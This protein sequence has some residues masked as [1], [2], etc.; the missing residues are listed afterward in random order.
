MANMTFKTNLLPNSTTF[1][2]SLGS[3]TDNK[4]WKIEGAQVTADLTLYT[5]SGDSP[6][7]IFQRGTLGDSY[8]DW[9][10]Y[11]KGGYL[12][13]AQWASGK[14]DFADQFCIDTSGNITLGKI[15]WGSVTGK[16]TIEDIKVTQTIKTDSVE[17][18]ILTTPTAQTATTTTTSAFS[19]NITA[20]A[21]TG[22]I[23]L[24]GL[25]ITDTNST[26]RIEFSRPSYN[27][28]EFPRADGSIAIVGTGT[29]NNTTYNRNSE[30]SSLIITKDS[31]YPG[32]T[33]TITLGKSGNKWNSIYADNFG[34]TVKTIR[35]NGSTSSGTGFFITQ[36]VDENTNTN[37]FIA[38]ATTLGTTETL[39]V[40]NVYI[41][42]STPSGTA[43]N[44]QGRIRLYGP[45]AAFHRIISNLTTTNSYNDS[46]V[47]Y[48]NIYL[49]DY[50]GSQYLIHGGS[51]NA[52]GSSNQPVYIAENGRATPITGIDSAYIDDSSWV[53]KSGDTMTGALRL[54]GSTSSAFNARGLIFGDGYARI[55]HN[56]DTYHLGIY[57]IGNIYLRP[58]GTV[59]TS[60]STPSFSA[61]SNGIIISSTDITPS[62]SNTTLG[63]TSNKWANI[64]TKKMNFTTASYGSTL[65]STDTAEAGQIFF[66]YVN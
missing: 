28:L 51:G 56:S 25:K 10:I 22:I 29:I 26:A 23:S 11:D 35:E 18:P 52:I 32:T 6:G 16:P 55:G 58:N 44:A 2:Y 49:Q 38:Q 53:K 7:L 30:N 43:G 54:P 37:Y 48:R 12:Y 63:T 34:S 59:D 41:G 31:V 42:N 3:S 15:P 33:N 39:G 27:Y 20:N 8:N 40:T 19:T 65:P 45:E 57:S 62:N 9:K 64:Y 21:S 4:K 47:R 5:P 17:R 36:P 61:G 14:S 1:E 46:G 24:K 13:F 66:L 50:T 60:G